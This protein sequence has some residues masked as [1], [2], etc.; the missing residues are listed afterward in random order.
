MLGKEAIFG[1]DFDR[2]TIRVNGPWSAAVATFGR[3]PRAWVSGFGAECNVVVK[4][5]TP[6]HQ[7]NGYRMVVET[8]I[9]VDRAGNKAWCG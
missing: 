9:R 1:G 2:Q 8:V 6:S 3:F 4:E 5:L 7:E